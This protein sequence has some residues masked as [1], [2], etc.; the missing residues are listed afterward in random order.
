M[1]WGE[2]LPQSPSSSAMNN[3][4]PRIRI[5]CKHALCLLTLLPYT[6]ALQTHP[7]GWWFGVVHQTNPSS[8]MIEFPQYPQG[9]PWRSVVVPVSKEA[10]GD[11]GVVNAD[12]RWG[13]LGGLRVLSEPERA[14]WREQ[15]ALVAAAAAV[16]AAQQQQEGGAAGEGQEAEH[17]GEAGEGGAG[18]DAQ[19]QQGV[20]V[21][22]A[23]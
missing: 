14:R 10:A 1:A 11:G 4:M 2:V 13:F 9:S 3:A 20:L 6:L 22:L 15:R 23:E 8:V 21:E 19:E 18:E 7:F 5:S 17:D 12:L 16:V